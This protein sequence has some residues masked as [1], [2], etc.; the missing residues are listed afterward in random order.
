VEIQP[1]Y[2]NNLLTFR[3]YNIEFEKNDE[4]ARVAIYINSTISYNRREDLEGI[5]NNL[6]IINFHG[7]RTV[8]IINIYRS[9]N[10]QNNV[11]QRVNFQ[12]QLNLI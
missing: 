9:F 4:K 12:T 3:G 2:P 7:N 8:R 10:P 11:N 5:K 6:V 1:N